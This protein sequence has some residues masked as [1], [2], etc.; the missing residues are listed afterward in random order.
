M[1]GPDRRIVP[2]AVVERRQPDIESDLAW[3]PSHTLISSPFGVVDRQLPSQ[4]SLPDRWDAHIR[5]LGPMTSLRVSSPLVTFFE[6]LP[7]PPDPSG[8][9]EWAA[10]GWDRPSEGTL[11]A[12]LSLD[13]ILGQEELGV[14]AIPSFDVYPN[15]FR[16]NGLIL[17]NPRRVQ[18]V[19]A[20]LHP[21]RGMVRVGVRFADGRVGRP[22][23]GRGTLPKDEQGVP[24]QPYVG[25]AGG[26]GGS[27]GWKFGAWVYPLPPDG[28]LEVFVA[29]PDPSNNEYSTMVEGSAVREAAQRARVI[30]S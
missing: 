11:P 12:T 23:F 14:V 3:T 25:F 28:P 6:P 26:G 20:I 13:A 1:T 27:G 22:E 2:R 7:P 18:E 24:T 10:P 17:F 15:G 9:R 16:V 8:A 21:P 4:Y 30:W 29:L 5:H 19:Q